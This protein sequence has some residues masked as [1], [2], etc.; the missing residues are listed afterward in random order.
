MKSYINKTK[1]IRSMIEY[2]LIKN[3]MIDKKNYWHKNDDIDIFISSL[4]C[5]IYVRVLSKGYLDKDWLTPP[6]IGQKRP[7]LFK[8]RA[9]IHKSPKN[10][11]TEADEYYLINQSELNSDDNSDSESHRLV[12]KNQTIQLKNKNTGLDE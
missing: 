8:S 7:E 9:G 4:Y 5:F 3:M 1:R 11:D 2:Y 10:S 6:Y 12:K